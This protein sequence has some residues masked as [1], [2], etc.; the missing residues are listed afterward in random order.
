LKIK[1]ACFYRYSALV[2]SRAVDMPASSL[3]FVHTEQLSSNYYWNLRL[4][5]SSTSM[6]ILGCW[7]PMRF[8]ATHR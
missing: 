2:V 6:I 3:I 1:I 7:V 5:H 8:I 4:V